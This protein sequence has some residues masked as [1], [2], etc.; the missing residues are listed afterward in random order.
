MSIRKHRVIEALQWLVANNP[1]YENIQINH[2]L[3]ETWENKSISSGIIDSIVQ[4]NANQHKREG[5]ATDLNDGNFEN[6]LHTAIAGISIKE[7]HINIGYVYSDI[8]NQ[9]QNPTLQLLSAVVNIKPTVSITNQP[10]S[11]TISYCSIGQLIPLNNWENPHYFTSAFPCLFL[12]R[13]RGYL[14]QQKKPMSLEA[15][16]K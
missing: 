3:L 9:R 6:D 7:D 16:A 2:R 11:T 15:W 4:C 5:Y 10:I 1:L 8:D 14:E 12:F 13:T